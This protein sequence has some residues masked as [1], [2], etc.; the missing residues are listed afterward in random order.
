MNAIS[1]TPSYLTSES[2]SSGSSSNPVQKASSQ[3]SSTSTSSQSPL[4]ISSSSGGFHKVLQGK[5]QSDS[6]NQKAA[7][8]PEIS[9]IMALLLQTGV[10]S[11]THQPLANETLT[12]FSQNTSVL[13]QN[14]LVRVDTSKLLEVLPNLQKLV[15]MGSG[16]LKIQELLKQMTQGTVSIKDVRNFLQ[17]AKDK[18]VDVFQGVLN[19][20]TIQ[21]S[22]GIAP[23]KWV[24]MHSL[25]AGLPFGKEA[26]TAGSKVEIPKTD[27]LPQMTQAAWMVQSKMTVSKNEP[28]LHEL[29]AKTMMPTTSLVSTLINSAD[30]QLG[31][32]LGK[33]EI[34]PPIK[35]PISDLSNVLQ[36]MVIKNA[37]VLSGDGSSSFKITLL[38]EGLGEIQV[39]IQNSP[40]VSG[41][42]VQISAD[43]SQ[44]NDLLNNSLANLRSGLESQGIPVAKVEVGALLTTTQTFSMNSGL[45]EQNRQQQDRKSSENSARKQDS[46]EGISELQGFEGIQLDLQS[47]INLIA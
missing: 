29:P 16:T 7:D 31:A 9:A 24:S 43:S 20:K 45:F 4:T 1:F 35:V 10:L 41:V 36:Q 38:P 19:L 32:V 17:A 6:Q 42:T 26:G 37:S 5:S 27:S 12:K 13:S 8:S 18:V 33:P 44:T 11:F 40:S 15:N 34:V 22:S 2:S 28:L 25:T 47:S 46:I 3:D 21:M 14:Q 39:L 23:S 30:H